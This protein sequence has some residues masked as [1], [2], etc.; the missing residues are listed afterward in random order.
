MLYYYRLK[1]DL[2]VFTWMRAMAFS[3]FFLAK[4]ICSAMRG[5]P[6]IFYLLKILPIEAAFLV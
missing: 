2:F 5:K 6:R 3:M 4:N 1:N